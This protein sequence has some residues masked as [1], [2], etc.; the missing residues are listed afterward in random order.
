[1]IHILAVIGVIAV[2]ITVVFFVV[3]AV[4]GIKELIR[5]LKLRYK[6]KHRFD[7]PPIAKCYCVDCNCH[8]NETGKCYRLQGWHTADNWF[9]WDATPRTKQEE[10]NLK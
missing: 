1:M 7:K 4:D 9:C 6:Q 2:A 3:I 10:E 8:N 5:N